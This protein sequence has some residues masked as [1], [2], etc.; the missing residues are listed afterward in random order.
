V[1]FKNLDK[2]YKKM[3]I[4]LQFLGKYR[5]LSYFKPKH[6]VNALSLKTQ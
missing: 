3:I 2:I 5:A 6:A 1:V 4:L